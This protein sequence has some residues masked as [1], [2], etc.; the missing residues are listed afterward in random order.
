MFCTQCGAALPEGANFCASCGYK[1]SGATLS[2]TESFTP[3]QSA[4]AVVAAPVLKVTMLTPKR[5]GRMAV[6]SLFWAFCAALAGPLWFGLKAE[7]NRVHIWMAICFL[8]AT[9]NVVVKL[10]L[11]NREKDS[12]VRGRISAI[13]ITVILALFTVSQLAAYFSENF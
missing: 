10:L 11:W 4:A 2:P 8:L 6:L 7:D 9:V 1:R 5:A 3:A 12:E 13:I